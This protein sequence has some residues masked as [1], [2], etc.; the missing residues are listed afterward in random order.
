MEL[1]LEIRE[2]TV[3]IG[4]AVA[5]YLASCFQSG[6]P[7]S[8][9]GQLVTDLLQ[10]QSQV[11][12]AGPLAGMNERFHVRFQNCRAHFVFGDPSTRVTGFVRAPMGTSIVL[13]QRG[14]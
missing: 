7:A 12:S 9:F 5:V 1:A 10:F 6:Q 3:Q 2:S 11:I 14:P 13:I 8:I 4:D